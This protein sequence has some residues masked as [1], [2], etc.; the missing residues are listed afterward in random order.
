VGL[1]QGLAASVWQRLERLPRYEILTEPR[2]KAFRYKE[3]IVIQKEF[4]NQ[5]LEGE[6]I[7]EMDYQPEKCRKPYRVVIVRKNLSVKQR[8]AGAL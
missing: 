6:D 4:K 2:P 3:Q 8:G 7:A 1:A 5:V